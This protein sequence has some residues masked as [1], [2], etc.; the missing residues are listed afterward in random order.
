MKIIIE[1]L[2]LCEDC[3]QATVNN[4]F[5][6]LDYHYNKEE[7]EKRY[8][9]ITEGLKRLGPHLVHDDRFEGD[10]FSSRACDCCKTHLSGKREYFAILG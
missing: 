6:G 8:H 3:T 10:E 7:S 5:S 9:E 2:A 1:N 4:D